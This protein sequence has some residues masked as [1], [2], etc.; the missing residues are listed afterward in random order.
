[1][2]LLNPIT[3]SIIGWTIILSIAI[4]LARRDQGSSVEEE[5]EEKKNSTKEKSSRKNK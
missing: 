1:M 5:K 2:E 3:T 4:W